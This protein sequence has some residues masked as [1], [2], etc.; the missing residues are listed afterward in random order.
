M[1]PAA[2]DPLRGDERERLFRTVD[3]GGSWETINV[4]LTNLRVFALAVDPAR[5]TCWSP[6][7]A[8]ACSGTTRRRKLDGAELRL[9]VRALAIDPAEPDVIYAGTERSGASRAA[10]VGVPG[11][12]GAPGS[13]SGNVRGLAVQAGPP[14]AIIAATAGGGGFAARRRPRCGRHAIRACRPGREL[15]RTGHAGLGGRL[16]GTNGASVFRTA[17]GGDTWA[18]VSAGSV[19]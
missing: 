11:R 10:R 13:G 12:L 5:T 19:V 1:K 6:G 7:H 2:R 15:A 18:D 8:T 4:G 9:N 14:D 17:D 3:G 16:R